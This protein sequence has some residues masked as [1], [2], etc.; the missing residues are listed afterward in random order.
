VS[1]ETI[2]RTFQGYWGGDPLPERSSLSTFFDHVLGEIATRFKRAHVNRFQWLKD[3]TDSAL[4]SGNAEEEIRY[5][6]YLH[7]VYPENFG[8]ILPTELG[9]T[10][11][12]ALERTKK[13]FG[14][15][16]VIIW[17]RL[18]KI[19]PSEVVESL[20]DLACLTQFF[21]HATLIATVT[22]I[23]WAASILWTWICDPFPL[24][25]DTIF[26]FLLPAEITFVWLCTLGMHAPKFSTSL[27]IMAMFELF[28]VLLR[29][30]RQSQDVLHFQMWSSAFPNQ[31]F[32][33][34]V[35]LLVICALPPMLYQAAVSAA[36]V[37]VQEVEV[38][39]EL[40]R[41]KLIDQL[42]VKRPLDPSEELRSW[43]TI[44][45][46]LGRTS[47]LVLT[48]LDYSAEKKS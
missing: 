42:H 13:L 28:W 11:L 12:A 2:L 30:L 31:L 9:N 47:P 40:F 15:D 37:Y 45:Q 38:A 18:L 32:L 10:M 44:S 14:I 43:Q 34:S 46:M 24:A 20:S 41:M 22:S 16:P 48:A 26:I 5:F 21:I 3:K 27:T 33:E 17:P 4:Q 23:I 6:F 29:S 25:L 7:S 36:K 39:F 19:L 35:C 1:S 8:M